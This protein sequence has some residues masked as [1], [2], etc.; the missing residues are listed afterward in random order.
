MQ[1]DLIGGGENF[2]EFTFSGSFSVNRIYRNKRG[3]T[4]PYPLHKQAYKIIQK[5]YPEYIEREYKQYDKFEVNYIFVFNNNQRR[6][7]SNYIKVFEDILFR[8][9]IKKDDSFVYKINVKKIIIKSFPENYLRIEWCE[10]DDKSYEVDKID[11][12]EKTKHIH[13]TV[14]TIRKDKNKKNNRKKHSEKDNQKKQ[15]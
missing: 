13:K 3:F 6:D 1:I 9:F 2:L 14:K 8:L 5:K 12:F 4:K 10:Y 11:I 15:T 7:V